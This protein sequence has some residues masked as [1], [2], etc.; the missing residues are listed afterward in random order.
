MAEEK[1]ETI[2]IPRVAKFFRRKKEELKRNP[3]VL[4]LVLI[5]LLFLLLLVL[6]T[7]LPISI[8]LK[9]LGLL[10]GSFILEDILH[11]FKK[12]WTSQN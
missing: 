8:G 4:I 5:F 3:H 1:K 12:L 11:S 9:I 2:I 6:V 10:I 7:Y